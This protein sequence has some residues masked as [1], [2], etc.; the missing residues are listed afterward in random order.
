M[1]KFSRRII[2]TERIQLYPYALKYYE[3]FFR[4][5]QKNKTRLSDSFP[6]L[7]KSTET[8]TDTKE[9]M[10]RKINDWNK[11]K[12]YALIIVYKSN[13]ELIGHFNLKEID[14]KTGV[15]EIAYFIDAGFEQRG[16]A[17]EVICRMLSVCFEDIGL[18]H[19]FARIV[20]DNIASQKAA[21]KSGLKYEGAFFKSHTM[22]DHT[23][24][25]T[26][27]YGLSREDY[28]RSPVR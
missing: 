14:W 18:N 23:M 12:N 21:E 13:H 26:Y 11:N 16:L 24:V 6:N 7:L 5:I 10:Q 4:L 8:D 3:P 1:I 15:G 22:H 27:R 2:E 28:L 20:S 9:F 19:V 25:E 17:T